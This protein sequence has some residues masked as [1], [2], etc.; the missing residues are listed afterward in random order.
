ML[1]PVSHRV[2]V[3][4][5][6]AVARVMVTRRVR[7]AGF[8]VVEHDSYASASSV[9]ARTLACALLDFELGDGLGVDVAAHLR[10][11]QSTLPIAFFTSAASEELSR[12][13]ASFGPLFAKPHELELAIAWVASACAAVVG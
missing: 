3:V 13:T 11:T 9:D 7:A 4:D 1:R 2:L 5:D 10:A 6:S 12:R 8:E